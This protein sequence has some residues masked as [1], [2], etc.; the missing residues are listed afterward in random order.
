[1]NNADIQYISLIK[2]ILANGVDKADR[3][4]V[5]TRSVF[6]RQMRFK[7]SE[8]LPLLTCKKTHAKSIIHELLWML[9]GDTNIKYLKDNNVTI[10]NEWADENGDLG[11]VYGH[12]WRNFNGTPD[13]AGIDQIHDIINQLNNNPDSRRIIVSAWNPYQLK[14][15]SLPPCHSF[16]QFYSAPDAYGN[17]KLS[18]QFYMRSNDFFL[19]NPFNIA[20]YAI[21][22]EMVAQV[23]N[24]IA[25]ELIWTGG[26][27]HIYTNH[28]NQCDELLKRPI[29]H[30]LPK[31]KLNP[32]IKNLLDFK[33]EDIEIIGY[34]SY[35]GIKAP[36]AV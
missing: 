19:G 25:D 35:P 36:V 23:T 27:V 7:M 3:T 12:Q 11:P 14:D 17:R 31:L 5:G 16:F 33:F 29:I 6:A 2:D 10:W 20:F 18:L 22:L 21:L 30:K 1:M 13:K 8:G 28:F 32:N 26:D 9:S 34:E 24:H 4:G 15:M